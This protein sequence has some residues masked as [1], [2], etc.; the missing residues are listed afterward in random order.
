ML[1]PF[2]PNWSIM[3]NQPCQVWNHGNRDY[4]P[5]TW[6]EGCVDGNASGEDQLTYSDSAGV[7]QGGMRAGKMDGSGVLA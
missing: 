1:E 5:L 3:E 7:Y 2:D 6:S 4:E